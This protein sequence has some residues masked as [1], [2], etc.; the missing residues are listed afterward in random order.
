MADNQSEG[1]TKVASRTKHELK[2]PSLYRVILVNDD[3]T[4]MDFVVAVLE[5]IFRRTPAEAAQIML[6]VHNRGQGVAGIY[7]KE[8]A[9]AK[10]EQVHQKARASGYPLR[11]VMEKQ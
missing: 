5:N 3:Y 8:I 9:E 4:T 2:E 6:S 7:A 11:C 1:G 10:V